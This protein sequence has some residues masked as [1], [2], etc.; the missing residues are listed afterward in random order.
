RLICDVSAFEMLLPL[1]YGGCIVMGENLLSLQSAPQREKVRLINTGP[2]LFEALLRAHA[3]LSGVTTVI[4]AG[5]KLSRRLANSV[6]DAAPKV[7]LLNCYGPTETTVYSSWARVDTSAHTEPT[8]GRPIWNTTLHVLER[9][10][11]LLPAGVDGELFI[12]GA[13]LARGY[14]G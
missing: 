4:L 12:G 9:G 7:K 6:F 1:S 8:I 11:E 14:L 13:G 2:S 3:L 5:E 10:G